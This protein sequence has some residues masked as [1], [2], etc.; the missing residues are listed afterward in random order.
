[1]KTDRS[2][3]SEERRKWFELDDRYERQGMRFALATMA[4]GG[5]VLTD[6]W[7]LALLGGVVVCIPLAGYYTVKR[8]ML[9]RPPK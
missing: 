6:I 7:P 4:C 3:W 9:G 8:H 5:L 1:M 2:K